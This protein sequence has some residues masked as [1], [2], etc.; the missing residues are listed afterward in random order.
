MRGS[1]DVV[2]FLF[3]QKIDIDA[4]TLNFKDTALHLAVQE[5]HKEI[6]ELLLDAHANPNIK[7]CEILL[8]LL[9]VFFKTL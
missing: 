7:N 6:V 8:V 4:Q 9:M 5:G 1:I 2:K 3:T